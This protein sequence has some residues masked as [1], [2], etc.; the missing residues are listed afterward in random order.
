VFCSK[1]IE[2]WGGPEDFAPEF[3]DYVFFDGVCG[4]LLMVFGITP[5][6]VVAL[7]LILAVS[8]IMSGLSGFGFSAVGALCL[9]MLPPKLG[10]PLLMTLSAANQIMSLAQLKNDLK[11]VREWWSGGP[12]P[13]LVGGIV[14][15]PVG[16]A[17]LHSLPTRDL[18]LTFGILLVLYS[19]YSLVWPATRGLVRDHWGASALVG[20]TGGVIG[21]FTAF[22]GAPVVVW[23]GL[24]HLSKHESRAIVQPFIFVLQIM[25]IVVLAIVHPET[26]GSQ[27]WRLL[28]ITIP[29]V[30]PCT[31][32]GVRLYRSLSDINFRR[33]SFILLGISGAGL[34]LK[35]AA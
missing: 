16:L 32:L 3:I 17:I 12:G 14:G 25:S 24:R 5:V 28:A 1:H 23:S 26:F 11:P 34:L 4:Y 8:A 7:V 31:L 33:V 29:V 9:I 19:V 10:V 2:R 22:P 13:Y 30:L 20:L 21:G 6:S 27:Y 15:V 35:A 18:M